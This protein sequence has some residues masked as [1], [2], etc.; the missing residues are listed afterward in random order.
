MEKLLPG[1][2]VN[3][4]CGTFHLRR[5]SAAV[6]EPFNTDDKYCNV[7]IALS[8]YVFRIWRIRFLTKALARN[9]GIQDSHEGIQESR[10]PG[11]KSKYSKK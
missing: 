4:I 10:I 11:R 8:A 9:S 7:Y 1:L 3:L 2:A 6:V 5:L